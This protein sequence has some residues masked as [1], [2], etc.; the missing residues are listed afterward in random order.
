MDVLLRRLLRAAVR[1]GLA[2]DWTW[3]AIAA[4]A[5]ALRRSLRERGGVVSSLRISPGEQLLISV[6]K[7]DD[8]VFESENGGTRADRRRAKQR[9][10]DEQK[11]FD[12]QLRKS[13]RKR[14]GSLAIGAGGGGSSADAVDDDA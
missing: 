9:V 1:R 8:P 7:W 13:A 4:C 14:G 3:L 12:K 2:G 10:K 6:R 5:F 11:Q